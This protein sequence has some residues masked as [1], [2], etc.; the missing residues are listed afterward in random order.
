MGDFQFLYVRSSAL[1]FKERFFLTVVIFFKRTYN[2]SKDICQGGLKNRVIVGG[3]NVNDI[4]NRGCSIVF[5]FIG[6]KA[7]YQ[8]KRADGAFP[9]GIYRTSWAF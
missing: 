6:D 1:R 4:Y 2:V 8:K 5:V 9:K 3:N 7:E